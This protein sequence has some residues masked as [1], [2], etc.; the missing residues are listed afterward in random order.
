M[1]HPAISALIADTNVETQGL[2]TETLQ[3]VSTPLLTRMVERSVRICTLAKGETFS[4]RSPWVHEFADQVDTWPHP[5][6]GLF[7]LAEATVYLRV[8]S[9]MTTAHELGHAIDFALGDNGYM[10]NYHP[11]VRR[12]FARATRWLTPYAATRIDEYVAESFRAFLECNDLASPWPAVTRKRLADIDPAM[13]E[14]VAHIFE[15]G[16]V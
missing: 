12:A 7:V 16:T 5:P 4:A 1:I 8:V 10:S 15:T 6:A 3:R 2:V 14:I 9:R 13:Y 11:G